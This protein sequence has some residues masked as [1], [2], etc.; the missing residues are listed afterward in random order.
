MWWNY[1]THWNQDLEKVKLWVIGQK[2][3]KMQSNYYNKKDDL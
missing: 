3:K 2:M 1:R